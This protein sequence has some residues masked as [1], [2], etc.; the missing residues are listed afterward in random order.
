MKA[1]EIRSKMAEFKARKELKVEDEKITVALFYETTAQLA[2]MNANLEEL[3]KAVR[4][5]AVALRQTGG[6][7]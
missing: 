5:V 6:P 7:R 2:D 4:E 3:T 1:K